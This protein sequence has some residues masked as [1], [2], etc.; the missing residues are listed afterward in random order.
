MA[1]GNNS[2]RYILYTCNIFTDSTGLDIILQLL[3]IMI[4]TCNRNI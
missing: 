1:Y 2:Y 4:M 3:M